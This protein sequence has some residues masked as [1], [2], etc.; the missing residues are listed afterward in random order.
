MVLAEDFEM[1]IGEISFWNLELYSQQ[2][3]FFV[4]FIS[5]Q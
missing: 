3:I 5:A 1:D 4:S 2:F